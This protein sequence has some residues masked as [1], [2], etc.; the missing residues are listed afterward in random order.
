[1]APVIYVTE[2]DLVGY[3]WEERPLGLRMFDPPVKGN[4]SEGRQEW[5]SG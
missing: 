1:M 5:V 3:Q 4:A 2:D